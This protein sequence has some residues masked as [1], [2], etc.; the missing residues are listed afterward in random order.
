MVEKLN[1]HRLPIDDSYWAEME[2][3]LQRK[4]KKSVP[5]WLWF[6]GTG[7]AASLSLLLTVRIFNTDNIGTQMTRIERIS[8]DKTTNETHINWGKSISSASSAGKENI[9]TQSTQIKPIAANNTTSNRQHKNPKKSFFPA[10]KENIDTQT[11]PIEQIVADNNTSDQ[12]QKN[13]DNSMLSASPDKKNE[14]TANTDALTDNNTVTQTKQDTIPEKQDESQLE[15]DDWLFAQNEPEPKEEKKQNRKSWQIAAAF[16]S[17]ASNSSNNDFTSRNNNL[18]D[19]S[20]WSSI[21][22]NNSNPIIY[23]PS[24]FVPNNDLP[25]DDRLF[26]EVTHLPPLSVG[27]TVRKNFNKYMAVETG[28]TYSFLQSKFKESSEFRKHNATQKLHY[29]GIPLN[30]VAYLLNK[31]K[32]NVYFSL[33]GMMEKGIMQD[34]VEHTTYLLL[35]PNENQSDYTVSSQENISGLQWSLNSSLGIGYKIYRGIGIYFEPRIIYYFKNNQPMSARTETPF[36][37]GL[38]AG[39]RFEFQ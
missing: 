22:T 1:N 8:I 27:L 12:Q 20:S 9:D 28:L 36:Q 3:R 38:N 5:F 34:Y 37:V 13:S 6:T 29:L 7:I 30:A 15:Y 39:F 23:P 32:W 31:P 10:K 24:Y 21:N 16:S 18:T 35:N 11:T 33:G 17:S 14:K 25:I 26:H 4:R 2:E 19:N